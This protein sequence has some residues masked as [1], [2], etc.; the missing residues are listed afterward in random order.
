MLMATTKPGLP[1][2][3]VL[4]QPEKLQAYPVK[5]ANR[6]RHAQFFMCPG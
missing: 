3:V 4:K 1:L 6:H 2:S 5:G